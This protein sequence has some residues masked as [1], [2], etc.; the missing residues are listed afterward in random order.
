ME[1]KRIK[2][3]LFSTYD[4]LPKP[5]N[6]HCWGLAE[7]SDCRLY[8][9]PASLEHVL[10][11]CKASLADDKLSWR[12]KLILT[13]LATGLEE[14]RRKICNTSRLTAPHLIRFVRA[15]NSSRGTPT[16]TGILTSTADW[17]HKS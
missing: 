17:G 7:N 13:E 15:G 5:L 1:E 2:F 14:K 12:H 9:K 6:H 16:G 3:L 8:R 11:S 10:S 4:L